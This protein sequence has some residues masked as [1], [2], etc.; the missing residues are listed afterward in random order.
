MLRVNPL[1]PPRPFLT[2]HR[3]TP[4]PSSRHEL[5]VSADD[6]DLTGILTGVDPCESRYWWMPELHGERPAY[7][8]T[9]EPHATRLSTTR[10]TAAA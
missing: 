10:S 3:G 5:L 6:Y 8:D 2:P 7:G 1:H 9:V 4:Q